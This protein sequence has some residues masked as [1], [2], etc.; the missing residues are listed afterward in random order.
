MSGYTRQRRG[1]AHHAA[2]LTEAKVRELRRMVEEKDICITCAAKLLDVGR[3]AAWDA[4][5]YVTWRH[6]RGQ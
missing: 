1:E 3:N 5:R 2:K 6:V 4:A